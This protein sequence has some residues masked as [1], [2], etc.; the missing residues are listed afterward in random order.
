VNDLSFYLKVVSDNTTVPVIITDA[1][2]EP[3]P[4]ATSASSDRPGAVAAEWRGWPTAPAIEIAITLLASRSSTS[5]TRTAVFT[6]L[7]G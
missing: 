7:Q 6:D 4:G 2:G 1:Q 5:T 3:I